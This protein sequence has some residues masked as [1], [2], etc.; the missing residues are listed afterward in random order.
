MFI[1]KIH[2]EGPYRVYSIEKF[3]N[4]REEPLHP[5]WPDKGEPT[6]SMASEVTPRSGEFN[7][8][9][10]K[11]DKGEE[12]MSDWT[13]AEGVFITWGCWDWRASIWLLSALHLSWAY[14]I[15]CMC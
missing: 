3:E 7:S 11:L 5:N 8:G 1:I 9:K 6:L 10:L 12:T 2:I 15:F 13:N 4:E 14:C